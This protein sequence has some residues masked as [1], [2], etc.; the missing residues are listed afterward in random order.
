MLAQGWI[1]HPQLQ[2]A[3]ESQKEKGGRI[4]E[5]LI[6]D[7]GIDSDK[8]TRGLSVQW[9]CPVLTAEDF[10]PQLMALVMP[11]LFIEEARAVPV[12][13]AS[14]RILYMGFEE[15]LQPSF[16]LALEHMTG[17]KVESGLMELAEFAAAKERLLAST[18]VE[19][20]TDR[21]PD[22]DALAA[23]VTALIEQSQPVNSR[24]VRVGNSYWLRL[25]LESGTL[26]GTGTLPR[27]EE[28]MCD[29][30]FTIGTR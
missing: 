27:S 22:V 10:R 25:W 8:V 2:A 28:D 18:T 20:K 5:R 6:S 15:R 16:A 24:L 30:V 3:L 7:C 11:S 19:T 4:G 12:R 21:L 17:M 14:S 13:V 29:H 9:S 23:R 1:T 26:S